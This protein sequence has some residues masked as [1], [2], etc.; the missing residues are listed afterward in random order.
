M[1]MVYNIQQKLLQLMEKEQVL[2]LKSKEEDWH[3]QE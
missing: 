1:Y 3:V 2:E